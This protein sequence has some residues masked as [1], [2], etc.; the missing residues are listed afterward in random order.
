M[1]TDVYLT[2]ALQED[3]EM[4][5]HEAA[6]QT[7]TGNHESYSPHFTSHSRQFILESYTYLHMIA[8]KFI[9]T[10]IANKQACRRSRPVG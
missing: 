3:E 8:I 2:H 6:V 4:C 7:C 1:Q 5:E 9:N 10:L